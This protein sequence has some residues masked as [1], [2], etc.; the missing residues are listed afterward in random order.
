MFVTRKRPVGSRGGS[1]D[2][3]EED[4]NDDDDGA[5]TIA[6]DDDGDG[7]AML[8]LDDIAAGAVDGEELR[9]ETTAR[10]C[11]DEGWSA[12]LLD[13]AAL[14]SNTLE[15]LDRSGGDALD[16]EVTGVSSP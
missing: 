1:D 12:R 5:D 9:T 10:L 16:D 15:E 8:L 3:D 13:A 11:D 14:V 6:D 2:E 4:D 7:A